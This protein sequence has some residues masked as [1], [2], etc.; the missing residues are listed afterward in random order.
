MKYTVLSKGKCATKTQTETERIYI[1]WIHEFTD[2]PASSQSYTRKAVWITDERSTVK[3]S[4]IQGL[5]KI[6]LKPIIIGVNI[7]II[8]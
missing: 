5:D 3:T 6:V 4:Y 8:A 1:Y 2:A 7:I